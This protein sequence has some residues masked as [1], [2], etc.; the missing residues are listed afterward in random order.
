[1]R[2]TW[3]SWMKF[4]PCRNPDGGTSA[5]SRSPAID[6]HLPIRLDPCRAGV[7]EV[8]RCAGAPA[9]TPR[10]RGS[11]QVVVGQVADDRPRCLL[12]G[13]V[14]VDFPMPFGP[15]GWSKNQSCSSRE[16]NDSTMRRVT[17]GTP[18]PMTKIS[19]SRTVWRVAEARACSSVG[20]W[21]CV[22]MTTVAR[23]LRLTGRSV[24]RRRALR[25]LNRRHRRHPALRVDNPLAVVRALGQ[26]SL[27]GAVRAAGI[28]VPPVWHEET[29]STND[30][31]LA[32]AGS[33]APEWTVV[34]TGHQTKGKGTARPNLVVMRPAGLL[35][36]SVLLR[37]RRPPRS[38]RADRPPGR[39]V[40]DRGSR[41]RL[42]WVEV[43]ERSRGGRPEGRGHP[44]RRPHRRG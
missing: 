17:S 4:S 39:G 21:S 15:F 31:A 25:T 29:G 6:E 36:V 35:L 28:D 41:C 19:R 20:P 16:A 9:S 8:G 26:E 12:E 3:R 44:G 14:A 5:S 27:E 24:E 22:G 38:G 1:M 10:A 7:R 13:G 2:S 42:A 37:P 32:L 33:G 30:D 11:Q 43:A 23:M 34:A 40:D 18:S